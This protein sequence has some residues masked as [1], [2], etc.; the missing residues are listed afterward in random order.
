[1][2][3]DLVTAS[4][5]CANLSTF[6]DQASKSHM[7]VTKHQNRSTNRPLSTALDTYGCLRSLKLPHYVVGCA[8]GE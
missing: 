6:G 1:M 5:A 4:R 8:K 2:L 3:H 7:S